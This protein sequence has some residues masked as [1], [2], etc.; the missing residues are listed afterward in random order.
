ML[1]A[2]P[3]SVCTGENEGDDVAVALGEDVAEVEALS[4]DVGDIVDD[5]DSVDEAVELALI[6]EEADAVVVAVSVSMA[7]QLEEVDALAVPLA[8]AV[9]ERVS[10]AL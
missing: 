1:L 9:D 3:V 2:D 6:D 4:V 8:D 5:A 7:D 10:L